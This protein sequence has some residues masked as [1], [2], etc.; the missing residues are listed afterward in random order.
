MP[1]TESSDDL[2]KWSFTMAKNPFM[3]AYLTAAYRVANT[4]L[5]KTT[6]EIKRQSKRQTTSMVNAW[7]D[8][9]TPK[10]KAKPARK[11]KTR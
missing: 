1:T 4:A 6:N 7:V 9:W 11:R 3:I 2:R 8:A 10:P 5:V